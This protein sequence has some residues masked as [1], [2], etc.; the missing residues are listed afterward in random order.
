[1]KVLVT[2]AGGFVG[3]AVVRAL[4]SARHEVAALRGPDDPT[5]TA[6][7]CVRQDVA[8]I[9][10]V[11]VLTRLA[12]GAD[13]VV[14][15]AGPPSVRR[16]F[17]APVEYAAVHVAGTAAVAEACACLGVRRLVHISSAEVYGTHASSPVKETAPLLPASPYAAAKVGAEAFTRA[18]T[19]R[20]PCTVVVLR[21]FSI[22]GPGQSSSSVLGT[23]IGH[24][25][26]RRPVVLHD[27]RP[28]RDYVW[29][30][31]VA[32]AVLL[33]GS[34]TLNEPWRAFNVTS[35]RGASVQE[36]ASLV[37]DAWPI[38]L[39]I[40]ENSAGA[41]P[42]NVDPQ[43]LFGDPTRADQELGFKASVPLQ[44]GIR[45]LVEATREALSL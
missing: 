41:R 2:G 11:A 30:D 14:H 37:K 45:L 18:L 20:A 42:T 29:I 33:A 21:P 15:A 31:D 1:M 19:R 43:V 17:D 13:V 38:D 23:I 32:S 9:R 10:D 4:V 5:S 44:D 8:D 39:P 26:A 3:S 25:A 34:V 7:A 40:V 28:V 16:S 12:G 27:L 24:V 35:G 6:P 36:V 22:Y